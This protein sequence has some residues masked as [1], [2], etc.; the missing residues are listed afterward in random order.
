VLC[1]VPI[2]AWLPLILSPPALLPPPSHL[3]DSARS[4]PFVRCYARAGLVLD[5]ATPFINASETFEVVGTG[6]EEFG[7]FN[8]A[9]QY[10]HHCLA[11]LCQLFEAA[12]LCGMLQ[13]QPW[14]QHAL[15]HQQR[16]AHRQSCEL[17]AVQFAAA[18]TSVFLN[19][20]VLRPPFNR[21]RVCCYFLWFM[22]IAPSL[23]RPAHLL[24][25][26]KASPPNFALSFGAVCA[27]CATATWCS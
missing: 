11:L 5:A 20:R 9:R 1:T 3:V 17:R 6:N 18:Q 22:Y 12:G 23:S 21:V 26:A 8:I 4:S 19:L 25:L 10:K 15:V 7:D 2:A 24:T 13:C 14:R 16:S 27:S